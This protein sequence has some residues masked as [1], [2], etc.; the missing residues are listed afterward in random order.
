[1]F[2]LDTVKNY[3]ILMFTLDVMILLEFHYDT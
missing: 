1:M 3:F 2:I